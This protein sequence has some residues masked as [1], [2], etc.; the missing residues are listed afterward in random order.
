MGT[1]KGVRQ[2]SLDLQSGMKMHLYSASVVPG[3]PDEPCIVVQLRAAVPTEMD[4]LAPSFKVAA[5]LTPW[6]AQKVARELFRFVDCCQ[7]ARRFSVVLSERI[8]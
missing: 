4:V 1:P 6:E 5:A 8:A 3:G 2:Y 7:Q